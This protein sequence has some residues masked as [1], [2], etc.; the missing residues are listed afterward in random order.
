MRTFGKNDFKDFE[1]VRDD[2][3]GNYCT[4]IEIQESITKQL[5]LKLKTKD[6]Y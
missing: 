2:N 1:F 5:M 6:Q 3:I 4:V